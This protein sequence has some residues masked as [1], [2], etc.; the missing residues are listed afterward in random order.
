[1]MDKEER[2]FFM[3]A[4]LLGVV[5]FLVGILPNM[6][7]ANAYQD[8]CVDNYDARKCAKWHLN[9]NNTSAYELGKEPDSIDLTSNW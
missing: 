8:V 4:G 2:L 3:C 5:V 1:M 6:L 7:A 9:N